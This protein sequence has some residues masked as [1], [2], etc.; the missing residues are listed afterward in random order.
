MNMKILNKIWNVITTEGYLKGVTRASQRSIF[1]IKDPM[2]NPK[3][4]TVKSH[5]F[6]EKS[7]EDLFIGRELPDKNRLIEL[8]H[9]HQTM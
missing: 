8:I 7:N 5:E 3:L 9:E 2:T 6:F 4:T 1:V